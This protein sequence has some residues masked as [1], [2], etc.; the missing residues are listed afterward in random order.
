MEDGFQF[1]FD[2]KIIELIVR[3][4]NNEI[5]EIIARNQENDSFQESYCWMGPMDKVELDALFGLMYFRGVLGSICLQQKNYFLK[6]VTT[7]WKVTFYLMIQ[8]NVRHYGITIDLLPWE[9]FGNCSIEI[10]RNM[11]CPLG[12]CPLMRLSTRSSLG[13]TLR[14]SKWRQISKHV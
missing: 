12:I 4:T 13:F 3:H 10:L 14:I 1:Y 6:K 7:F 11:L 5:H 2:N 8:K 9:K